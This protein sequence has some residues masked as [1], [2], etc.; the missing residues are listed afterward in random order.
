[1]KMS[2]TVEECREVERLAG[3]WWHTMTMAVAV[4]VTLAI[5]K[6]MAV[7]G[8]GEDVKLA[9]AGGTP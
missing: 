1:M 6:A 4:D 2:V 3:N 5:A 8:C 9:V 7:R